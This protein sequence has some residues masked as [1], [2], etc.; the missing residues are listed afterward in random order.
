METFQVKSIPRNTF[1][2]IYDELSHRD[3]YDD[4]KPV[5]FN[6]DKPSISGNPFVDKNPQKSSLEPKQKPPIPM[7]NLGTKPEFQLKKPIQLENNRKKPPVELIAIEIP[8]KPDEINLDILSSSR[9]S[10]EFKPEFSQSEN[11]S[12][13]RSEA[14]YNSFNIPKIPV[15]IQTNKSYLPSESSQKVQ[16]YM[17]QLEILDDPNE[18]QDDLILVMQESKIMEFSQIMEAIATE[19]NRNDKGSGGCCT[20]KEKAKFTKLEIFHHILG[21]SSFDITKL[22]HR[23]ILRKYIGC[24]CGNEVVPRTFEW[25]RLLGVEEI[26]SEFLVKEGAPLGLL[27][28]GYV[29]QSVS[30]PFLDKILNSG[31]SFMT[32]VMEMSVESYKLTKL[33]KLK[34]MHFVT[35]QV[36]NFFKLTAAGIITWFIMKFASDIENYELT[37]QVI[38]KMKDY[39]MVL[40]ASLESPLLSDPNL[41]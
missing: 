8:L 1:F 24:M 30:R 34:K 29:S 25:K 31:V 4:T 17:R 32:I 26:P 22:L 35:N 13:E 28:G 38:E 7:L 37:Q 15:S 21:E 12:R 33:S 40:I 20:R 18:K 27:L 9:A 39:S 14:S 3:G 19:C 23:N 16:K 6:T 11:F 5:I 41:L 10:P 36:N 2:E